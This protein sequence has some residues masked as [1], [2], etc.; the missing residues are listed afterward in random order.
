MF[1]RNVQVVSP[2][3]EDSG[4]SYQTSIFVCYFTEESMFMVTTI[5][6]SDSAFKIAYFFFPYTPIEECIVISVK[7]VSTENTLICVHFHIP[8][9]QNA[10]IPIC[11][12][13]NCERKSLKIQCI[14]NFDLY[15]CVLFTY[16]NNTEPVCIKGIAV[17][18]GRTTIQYGNASLPCRYWEN[19]N[20]L[21]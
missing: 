15:H 5:I 18:H 14:W 8:M 2:S 20:I 16:W 11:R 7:D 19:R 6:T 21:Q 13:F 10:W 17:L 4:S 12:V 9:W 3:S 1:W